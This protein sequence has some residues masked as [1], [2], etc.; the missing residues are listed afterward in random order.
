[1]YSEYLKYFM[2][3]LGGTAF[4][5]ISL[6]NGKAK[7]HRLV[8]LTPHIA[9]LTIFTEKKKILKQALILHFREQNVSQ[10]MWLLT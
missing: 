7:I 2:I 8:N 1:M 10:E 5:D 4:W 3:A 9:R 6:E